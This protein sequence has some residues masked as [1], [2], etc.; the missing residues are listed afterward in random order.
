MVLKLRLT[1]WRQPQS[2]CGPRWKWV[3]HPC[4]T[5]AGISTLLFRDVQFS[6]AL[7]SFQMEIMLWRSLLVCLTTKTLAFLSFPKTLCWEAQAWV[8]TSSCAQ[9]KKIFPESKTNGRLPVSLHCS[10]K[11]LQKL[12]LLSFP[13]AER[14]QYSVTFQYLIKHSV[15]FSVRSFNHPSHLWI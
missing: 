7:Y 9:N 12:G 14:P 5:I 3:W 13:L 6:L 10:L 1:L 2:W 4:Y 11:C 8:S 15:Q